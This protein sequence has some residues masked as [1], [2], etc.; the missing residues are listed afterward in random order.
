M[1]PYASCL[2]A[3]LLLPLAAAAATPREELLRLVPDDVGFCLVVQ[4]FRGHADALQTSPFVQHF[5][6]S[7]LGL[8]LKGSQAMHKLEEAEKFLQKTLRVDTAPLRDAICGDAVVCA[9]R[10]GPARPAKQDQVL[11][12]LRARDPKL[13]AEL[14]DRINQVQKETGELKELEPREH[15]GQK[16]FHRVDRQDENF[17][18]LN[19]PI[20][21]I[22][23]KEDMLRRVLERAQKPAADESIVSRQLRLLNADRN[24]AALWINPRAFEP[25]MEHKAAGA[26][27]PE[28]AVLQNVLRHWKT[29]DGLALGFDV[30]K[31]LELSRTV[32]V[33]M[34]ALPAATRRWLTEA[35]RQSELW[36]RFPEDALLTAAGRAD[37]AALLDVIGDL[38]SQP[39]REALHD[40]L[41]RNL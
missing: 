5:R 16:Y 8:A 34:E 19:G 26:G 25:E 18:W 15:G 27:A 7:P 20:L 6:R 38:L 37:A 14:L 39:D 22:S 41:E 13:L 1:K 32:R 40:G 29:L 12:L 2:A 9:Y 30:R 24:L 28:A 17:Y 21:A 35:A 33:R 36:D 31:D 11:I 4:D 23:S 10:P 3:F